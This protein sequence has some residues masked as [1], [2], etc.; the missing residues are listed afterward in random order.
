M[1]RANGDG[2]I[3]KL[4]GNRRKPYAIRR[5]VGWKENGSP[6]IKYQGYFRTY[7]EAEKALNEYNADPYTIS[8]KTLDDIYK[9]WYAQRELDKA[10]KTLQNYRT[11][12]KHLGPLHNMKVKDIDRA[13][14]QRFVDNADLTEYVMDRTLLVLHLLLEYAVKRNIIPISALNLTKAIDI[15][16]KTK[17]AKLA[18]STIS[19][20]DIL[21]L[22]DMQASDK[23]AKIILFYL[24]TGLRYVELRNLTADCWHEDHIEIRQAKTEAGVRIVPLCDK[25]RTILP[26]E[27]VPAYNKYLK[28]FTKLLPEHTPHE[29]RHTFISRLVENKIDDRIIKAIVGHKSNDVTEIYTHL[30]LD[31]LL[32][33]VNTL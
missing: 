23:Y 17:S 14:L 29:T 13:V 12:Y 25:I 9:E 31:V 20:A 11:M 7:R 32:N 2:T 33:A 18:R 10:D 28:E 30:P 24:Y 26:I 15:P 27:P 1:R 4:S 16:T 21:R 8:K 5:V 3:A 22:W 19:K 6:I